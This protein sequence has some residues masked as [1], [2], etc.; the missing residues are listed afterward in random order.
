[1]IHSW[2]IMQI[3]KSQHMDKQISELHYITQDVKGMPHPQLVLQACSAGVD[4]VQLRLK[5]K[6]PEEKLDIARETKKICE[7]YGSKLIINDDVWIAER[8]DADG[9][10]LGK[11]DM[12][13]LEARKI[14]GREKIIGGTANTFADITRLAAAGVDYIGLGPFR[15]TATKENLSPVLGFEGYERIMQQCRESGMNIPVIAIGGITRA[16]VGSLKDKGVY[17]VAV[18]SAISLSPLIS[19]AVRN[20][21]NEFLKEI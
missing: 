3:K 7:Q 10:H 6:S 11:T 5:N 16:D 15:F 17:G 4:W 21:R 2:D 18:S 12:D 1:M 9:V 20:F 8:V 19:D 13:P 14:L